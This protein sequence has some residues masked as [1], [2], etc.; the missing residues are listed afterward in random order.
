VQRPV[1]QLPSGHNGALLSKLEFSW[2]ERMDPSGGGG[3]H[4]YTLVEGGSGS[5]LAG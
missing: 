5:L 1:A 2:M 4:R 3:D